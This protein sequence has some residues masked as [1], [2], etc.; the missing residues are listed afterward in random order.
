ML[1][2]AFLSI[3]MTP[4]PTR[5]LFF[6]D[7]IT[8]MGISPDG[9]I[10]R[11]RSMLQSRGKADQFELIG[12]GIGGN[13]IYDLY[14]RMEADVLAQSP[15]LVVIFIGVNDVW[16]KRTSG[17]GTD[18]DKFTR[19]YEAIIARL[20][21]KGAGIILVTPALIGEKKDCSNDLDGELNHYCQLI[22]D[23]AV[24]HQLH[25][26]D[27]RKECLRTIAEQNSS[28]ADRG[29]LTTDGVHFSP[30]GNQLAATLFYDAITRG[31]R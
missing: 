16:H 2:L 6:G 8:E 1:V 28:D 23:L 20:Q 26:V 14:L 3:M 25:L 24:K 10:T 30:A 11:L 27:L 9:Y 21:E 7:S 31:A 5:V 19:F 15:D 29:I 13:K 12:A 4:R 18:P 22:R 17:T